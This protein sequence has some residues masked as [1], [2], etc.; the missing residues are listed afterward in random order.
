VKRQQADT[1]QANDT[2]GGFEMVIL[3]SV[4]ALGDDAYGMTIQEKAEELAERPDISI[5]AVYTTLDRL[6]KKGF[7]TSVFG[8]PSERGHRPRK[9]YKIQAPGERAL[10]KALRAAD[11]V[12]SSL[13][14]IWGAE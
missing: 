2:L 1:P 12:R 4:A 7:A 10:R 5:G 14:P 9:Y 13:R 3:A 11:S 8:D 6:E